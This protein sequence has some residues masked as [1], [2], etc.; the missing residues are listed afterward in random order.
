MLNNGNMSITVIFREQ[1]SLT[2][3]LVVFAKVVG[4]Y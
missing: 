3:R 4:K 2:D 1:Q